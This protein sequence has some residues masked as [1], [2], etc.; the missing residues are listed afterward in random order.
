MSCRAG[1]PTPGKHKTWGA[2]ARAADIQIDRHGLQNLNAE[3]DKDRRLSRYE[4]ARNQ[5]LQPK[6]TTWKHVNDA[7]EHG[8]V[9]HSKVTV[10]GE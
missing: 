8:G 4:D 3:K 2:C 9:E 6:N 7:F 5:G 10:S 1:C